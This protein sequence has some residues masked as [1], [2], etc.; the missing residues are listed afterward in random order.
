MQKEERIWKVTVEKFQVTYKG[1]SLKIIE[2]SQEK[3]SKPGGHEMMYFKIWKAI[4][5]SLDDY[6]QQSYP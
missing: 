2:I 1:K 5:G 3:L 4:T 6:I